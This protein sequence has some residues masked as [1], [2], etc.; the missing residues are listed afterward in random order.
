MKKKLVLSILLLIAIAASYYARFSLN[1]EIPS[2]VSIALIV[3]L[4]LV[5][6]RPGGSGRSQ[7][8]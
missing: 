2:V 6:L 3:L 5:H 8:R 4:I 1:I 7:N